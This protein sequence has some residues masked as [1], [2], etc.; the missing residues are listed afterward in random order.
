MKLPHLKTLNIDTLLAEYYRG[1]RTNTLEYREL[2]D[3][4]NVRWLRRT[5]EMVE[6]PNSTDVMVYLMFEDI[7]AQKLE[8]I[9]NKTLAETDPLTGLLNRMAFME[10]A[11]NILR[12]AN[13]NLMNAFIM[14]DLD[15]FKDVN[16]HLGHIEGDKLLI[17]VGQKLRYIFQSNDLICRLGGDEFILCICDVPKKEILTK[18]AQ[19]ICSTLN[20]NLHDIHITASVGIAINPQDGSDF[21]ELYHKVDVAMYYVKNNGKNNYTYYL[22]EMESKKVID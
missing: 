3:E 1:N 7:N 12:G 5:V 16:D 10:K 18:R 17:E 9:K 19:Q 13:P 22:S 11:A 15:N 6:Y 8:E 21:E 4:K 2:V 14:L 20:K